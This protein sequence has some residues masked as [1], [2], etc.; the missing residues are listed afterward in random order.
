MLEL[1]ERQPKTIRFKKTVRILR[2]PGETPASP[3][4]AITNLGVKKN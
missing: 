3:A 2:Q 4:E 1:A